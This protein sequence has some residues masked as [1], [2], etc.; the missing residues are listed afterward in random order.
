MKKQV[1]IPN[2]FAQSRALVLDMRAKICRGWAREYLTRVA[3][4]M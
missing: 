3:S 2:L 1:T 4:K